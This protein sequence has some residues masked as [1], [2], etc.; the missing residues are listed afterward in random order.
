VADQFFVPGTHPTP[1]PKAPKKP[2][3][4]RRR[5]GHVV[6]HKAKKK[7]SNGHLVHVSPDTFFVPGTRA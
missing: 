1:Q 2:K 5:K 3:K 6:H 7:H 4:A